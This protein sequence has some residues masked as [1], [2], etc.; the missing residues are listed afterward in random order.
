MLCNIE[1]N[2]INFAYYKKKTRWE[3]NCKKFETGRK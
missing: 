1:K 2:K 3:K